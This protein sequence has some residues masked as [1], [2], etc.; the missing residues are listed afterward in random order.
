MEY[1]DPWTVI[2]FSLAIFAV[3]GGLA[4]LFWFFTWVLSQPSSPSPYSGNLLR[5]AKDLSL[6]YKVKI[7]EYLESIQD[8]DNQKFPF[9]KAS[10]CRDTL[11]LFP[12][13]TTWYGAIQVDWTFLQKR[14]PGNYV[15]WGS[16]NEKQKG[17][18]LE[19]HGSLRG[20]QTA[21]SSPE[22]SPRLIA[23]EYAF[24]K[25]GPLYVDL[26]TKIVLGWKLVPDTEMEVL[27][28]QKPPRHTE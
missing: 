6:F 8:Y 22:S 17:A 7:L 1:T 25:P 27:I 24:L 13:S 21:Q 19:I 3:L 11:R 26:D 10:Y 16:L 18:L 12:N 2:L 4:F 9:D 14:F 28:V 5:P 15:S 23:P 20:F